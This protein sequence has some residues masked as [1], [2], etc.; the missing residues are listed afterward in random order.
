MPRDLGII[1]EIDLRKHFTK[2]P[3]FTSW[4]NENVHLLS[5]V[6]GI[7]IIDTQL[8]QEVGD[9]RLD[10]IGVDANTKKK[11][12]IENQLE[13]TNHSHLGQI[14]TYASGIDAGIAIWIAKEIRSEHQQALTWLNEN[15]KTSFFG[16]EVRLIRIGDSKPAPDFR[17]K[18]MPN[19]WARIVK[20]QTEGVSPKGEMYRHFFT[21]LIA[22]YRKAN[23]AIKP[24]KAQPQSWLSFG[25]GRSGFAF[26]WAFR[27]NRRFSVELYIDPGDS[28]T[29]LSAFDQ[30]VEQ[31][32]I[33]EKEI[34]GIQ[35]ERLE[36]RRACRIAIY[37]EG[38]I[39]NASQDEALESELI[40]WG[41]GKMLLFEKL[42]K[43][44]I[45]GLTL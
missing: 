11:V 37:R 2:E 44:L 30:L 22:G 42:F 21:K 18:V 33:A 13:P 19:D 36:E 8:E 23:P 9:Y 16:I 1:E 15:S 5:K 32:E 26:G 20:E 12:A 28:E 31:K 40:E 3:D 4:L 35:W 14:I 45:A 29:N 25:A 27:A 10:I 38:D 43:K 6:I 7:E 41:T 17:V 34:P 39:E 24:I